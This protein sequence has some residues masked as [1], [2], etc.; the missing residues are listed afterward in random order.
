MLASTRVDV[1]VDKLV[2][3]LVEN[4][5]PRVPVDSLACPS[6]GREDPGRGKRPVPVKRAGSPCRVGSW[7]RHARDDRE[8]RRSPSM[9][10][11]MRRSASTAEAED[12]VRFCY[13]RRRV[14]WPDL[15]DE[16]CR[17]AHRGPVQGHGAA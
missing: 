4:P 16:M 14:G 8:G 11:A 5:L 9:D 6:S 12:F 3:E 10:P 7:C 2:D 13:H 1:D 15:Y 17:V